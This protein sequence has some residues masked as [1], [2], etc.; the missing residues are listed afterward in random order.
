MKDNFIYSGYID[1]KVCDNL[2]NFYDQ[3]P[4]K[5]RGRIG[6]KENSQVNKDIKNCEEVSLHDR[7]PEAYAYLT[8]LGKITT[9]F[10]AK[11]VWADKNQKTWKI[12]SFKIQKYKPGEGYYAWHFENNG[13]SGSITRHLVFSTF[14]NDVK[15]K[16]ETAFYYQKTKIKAKKGKTIIFPAAWT[17]THKGITSNTETKYIVT[18]WYNYVD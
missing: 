17:H 2:I 9:K 8:E 4:D 1:K 10:K 7:I 5:M 12:S 3:S 18:G 15:D 11:Y 14:L 13:S 6:W 16:G